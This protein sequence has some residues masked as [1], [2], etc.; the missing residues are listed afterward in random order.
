MSHA[1]WANS[2]SDH[3]Y[4]E[5]AG[6]MVVISSFKPWVID[7]NLLEHLMPFAHELNNVR[8]RNVKA[9][10]KHA[11]VLPYGKNSIYCACIVEIL[12]IIL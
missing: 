5:K 12:A 7:S 4:S 10:S 3:I 1:H 2:Y 8:I 9:T 11:A 6:W